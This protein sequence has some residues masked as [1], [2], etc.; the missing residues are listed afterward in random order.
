MYSEIQNLLVPGETVEKTWVFPRTRIYATN[1]RLFICGELKLEDRTVNRTQDISYDHVISIEHLQWRKPRIRSLI[2]IIL[3]ALFF[4]LGML[5]SITFSNFPAAPSWLTETTYI[6]T[7]LGLLMLIGGIISFRKRKMEEYVTI[8]TASSP[9]VFNAEGATV[10]F[11]EL[12]NF[13]RN[14]QASLTTKDKETKN[15]Q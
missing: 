5:F 1:Q 15:K 6:G 2:A 9:I 7:L 14:R 3:G 13:I 11:Q 4:F 10:I 8:H 12:F